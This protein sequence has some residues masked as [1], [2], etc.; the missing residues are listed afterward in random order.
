MSID[1]DFNNC[2]QLND[3]YFNDLC[4]ELNDIHCALKYEL[5]NEKIFLLRI[6]IKQ[7]NKNVYVISTC[8]NI[9]EYLKYIDKKYKTLGKIII[10]AG[11]FIDGVLTEK[12]LYF[13]NIVKQFVIYDD[14]TMELYDTNENLYNIFIDFIIHNCEYA[15]MSNKYVF[16]AN[17]EKILINLNEEEYKYWNYKRNKRIIF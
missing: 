7:F 14:T 10:I 4:D 16:L 1:D 12:I 11:G 3:E 8:T 13:K 9:K 5:V 17:Q 6:W 15:F 2:L